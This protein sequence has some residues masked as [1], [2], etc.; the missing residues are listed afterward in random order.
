[1]P[2][3]HYHVL[4]DFARFPSV[5]PASLRAGAQQEAALLKRISGQRDLPIDVWIDRGKRVRRYQVQVP[6]CFQ[7][8]RTS[9][10]IAIELYDYG[11]QSIPVPPPPSEASDL[12]SEVESGASRALQQIHC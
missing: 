6:F 1:V 12:T 3:T 9:E 11:T 5:V 4:V 8:E 2:T 10:A 7:S